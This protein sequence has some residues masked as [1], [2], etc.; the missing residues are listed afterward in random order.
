MKTQKQ[1]PQPPSRLPHPLDELDE[2]LVLPHPFREPELV[3]EHFRFFPVDVLVHVPHEGPVRLAEED[4]KPLNLDEILRKIRP[5]FVEFVRPVRGLPKEHRGGALQLT[6]GWMRIDPLSGRAARGNI[7]EL[8]RGGSL[9]VAARLVNF[10]PP[11]WVPRRDGSCE[12][13]RFPAHPQD[14][15]NFLTRINCRSTSPT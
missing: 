4:L 6:C 8:T 13:L 7:W 1:F 2:W 3:G 5:Q 14:V 10:R 12:A 15:L 9:P 11:G